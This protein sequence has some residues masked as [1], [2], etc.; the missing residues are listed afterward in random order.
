MSVKICKNNNTNSRGSLLKFCGNVRFVYTISCAE[1]LNTFRWHPMRE[2]LPYLSLA[3]HHCVLLVLLVLSLGLGIFDFLHLTLDLGHFAFQILLSSLFMRGQHLIHLG[4]H[5]ILLHFLTLLYGLSHF[6]DHVVHQMRLISQIR[7]YRLSLLACLLYFLNH[8][9][10]L[11]F[12][13]TI[14]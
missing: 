11:L 13:I 8:S 3:H 9:F 1:N 14:L 10:Q 4:F 12:L 2:P 6:H 5:L 7:Q